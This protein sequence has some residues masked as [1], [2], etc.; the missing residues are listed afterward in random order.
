M[1]WCWCETEILLEL[2]I[3]GFAFAAWFLGFSIYV[4]G[5]ICD[6]SRLLRWLGVLG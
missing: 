5:L 4:L 3:L 1:F 6:C 2:V